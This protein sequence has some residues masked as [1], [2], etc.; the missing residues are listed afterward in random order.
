MSSVVK[1]PDAIGSSSSETSS[2]SYF[3]LPKSF[4]KLWLLQAC[5]LNSQSETLAS[6]VRFSTRVQFR[7]QRS[8]NEQV[9]AV[10]A[11]TDADAGKQH[12]NPSAAM[13][14][15]DHTREWAGFFPALCHRS[16]WEVPRNGSVA[17]PSRIQPEN[18][19]TCAACSRAGG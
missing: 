3:A 6:F 11:G 7:A 13:R 5:L 1:S 15:R 12:W 19:R 4:Q 14:F 8:D 2:P 16:R 17:L 9:P 18:D 10:L